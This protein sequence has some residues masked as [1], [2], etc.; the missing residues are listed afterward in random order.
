M[1]V[2][3]HGSGSGFKSPFRVQAWFLLRSREL[4]RQK[5]RECKEERDQ[6]RQ[7]LEQQ[8]KMLEQLKKEKEDLNEQL[9]SLKQL[10]ASS[11]EGE[12]SSSSTVSFEDPPIGQHGYG[13]RMVDLALRIVKG[14]VPLRATGRVLAIVF[15]VLGISGKTPHWTTI[16]LWLKRLGHAVL[17]TPVE[18]ADD[19]AWLADHSVQIGEEKTLVIL[20]VR[21]AKLPPPGQAL[22]HEDVR[23]IVVLPRKSWTKMDVRDVLEETANEHGVPRA[24]ITDHGS[25]LLGGIRL[26]QQD[27]AEVIEL[28]DFKHRA[29]CRLKALLGQDEQFAEFTQRLG[30]TRC[31]I[32]Q[33]E[34]GFLN[35][36]GPKPKARFMNLGPS[37]AWAQKMLRLLDNRS[38]KT[39]EWVTQHRLQEKLGWLEEFREPLAQWSECQQV[40][41]A[42][43]KFA[44]EQGVFRHAAKKLRAAMPQDLQ[45]S[46]S[47]SLADE[48]VAFVADEQAKLK[49]EERLPLSTEVVESS[50]AKY[51]NLERQ[52]PKSGFTSL[53]LGF[54]ALLTNITPERIRELFPMSP[55]RQVHQWV[56]DKLGLTVASK[57]TIAYQECKTNA[58]DATKLATGI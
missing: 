32:Q 34:L 27:H 53:L 35:P 22:Q 39:R 47:R 57:R 11:P 4:N 18:K 54:G 3:C 58:I 45:H 48:L 42:G 13:A 43:V 50:F 33:T 21:A 23:P 52:H 56:R 37:L 17:T 12:T 2:S 30:Q 31:A 15:E 16:R 19:W 29:A 10:A 26:F 49:P 36:P 44:N 14:G 55:V 20:G 1:G 25:D 38:S 28:Y 40:V 24:I 5:Y 6:L 46:T 51:K 8:Q 41:N 9:K 7:Q